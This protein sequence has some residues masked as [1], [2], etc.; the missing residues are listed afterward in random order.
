MDSRQA[1]KTGRRVDHVYLQ[2]AYERMASGN[3]W[4]GVRTNGTAEC[5]PLRFG[6]LSRSAE[7]AQE[8]ADLVT[9]LKSRLM[10]RGGFS[11]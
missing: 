5:Q 4:R 3:I 7:Q 10:L 6:K 2:Y 11:F 1:H 8:V 9:R